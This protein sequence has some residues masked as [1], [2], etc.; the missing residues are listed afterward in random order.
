MVY[1]GDERLRAVRQTCSDQLQLLYL[2]YQLNGIFD[3]NPDLMAYSS[4]EPLSF[5]TT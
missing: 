2:F 1:D 3:T 4:S 5:F